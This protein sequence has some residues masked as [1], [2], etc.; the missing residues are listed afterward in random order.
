MDQ[1][2]YKVKDIVQY[3][4]IKDLMPHLIAQ[5]SCFKCGML[6]NQKNFKQV[7]P[8]QIFDTID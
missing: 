8:Q 6:Y 2:I 3:R 7:P 5:I 1:S 4:Q